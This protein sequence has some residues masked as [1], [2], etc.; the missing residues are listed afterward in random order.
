MLTENIKLKNIV[1]LLLIFITQASDTFSLNY[2][3]AISSPVSKTLTK[4]FFINSST[5]WISGDSGTII[6]TTNSGN[7]WVI[8]NSGTSNNIEDIFF[9]NERLGWA[10]TYQVFPDSNE[11]PGTEIL[12]TT[13]GGNNWL[14]S[15]FPDTNMFMKS[16]YYLD[17]LKG[18]L[19]GISAA[20]VMTTNAGFSWRYTDTDSSLLFILPVFKID[21]YD[22]NLGY[23]CGGFRDISG[24][25]WVTTNGGFNWKGTILAPEP[26]FDLTILNN[27]KTICAGGDL[28]YGSS[29]ARTTDQGAN[30]F[31]DT[32]GVFG[33]ATGIDNRTPSEIWM[34]TSYAEK[35]I[36]SLDTGI[37]WT[38]LETPDNSA[39]FD[40]DFTDT[41]YGFACGVNGVILKYDRTKSSLNNNNDLLA[42]RGFNLY[43][44]YPNPFN[45][46]TVI[47]YSLSE[48]RF[49]SIKIYNVL[50]HEVAALVSE[51]QNP[52]SYKVEFDGTNLPSG[53]YYY[54]ITSGKY[55][56]IKRMVLIK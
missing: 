11:F 10:L 5:G 50:G 13:N 7:N 17:S 4:C 29:I 55:S 52:G 2:W 43:Q 42:D 12:T 34:A 41:T 31:Y 32:L 51:K 3:N 23:A 33:L 37:T 21:F 40:L 14:S 16:V 20:I 47:R 48:T 45:P 27:Q 38:A 19:G 9:L 44:N 28:E 22:N 1:F 49:T 6:R 8:Q 53:I 36:Y 30:W 56:A 35:F 15:M 46:K 26:F 24:I 39:I 18:F 54:K 25:T